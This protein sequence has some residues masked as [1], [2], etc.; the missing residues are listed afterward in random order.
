M[1]LHANA[2][3][4]CRQ[5]PVRSRLSMLGRLLFVT[6]A[7]TLCAL[8]VR[9]AELAATPDRQRAKLPIS[10]GMPRVRLQRPRQ[11]T[12]DNGMRLLVL[13]RSQ[14]VPTFTARMVLTSAGGL[15]EPSTR[16]GLAEFTAEMLRE[17]T[18]TRAA[19]EVARQLEMLG[20]TLEVDASLSTSSASLTVAGLAI[21]VDPALELLADMI[22]NPTFRSDEAAHYASR[23]IA[24]LELQRA[25]PEF[26]SQE[27]LLGAIYGNHPAA[28][29]APE[30]ASI[31]ATTTDD[32][33]HFHTAHYR[34]DEALLVVVG[35]VTLDEVLPVV[36]RAFG[37][38]S[39]PERYRAAAP[40]P[41][42]PV[43]QDHAV[44]LV[45]RPG[46]VQTVIQIGTLGITRVD[47]D[48]FALLVM[49][50]IFGAQSSARLYQNLREKHGYT[51]GAYSGFTAT[52]I[53]GIWQIT[54]SVR[55]DVTEAAL[56]ELFAEI[57]RI[58]E[59][60]A[61]AAELARAKRAL[62]GSYIFSLEDPQ[63]LLDAVI[64]QALYGLSADYWDTYPQKVE[65]VSVADVQRVA[66]RIVDPQRLQIAAVGDAAKV[67]G[68]LAPYGLTDKEKSSATEAAAGAGA[69]RQ[70]SAAEHARLREAIVR[71]ADRLSTAKVSTAMLAEGAAART[72]DFYDGA[73]GIGYF[74]LKAYRVLGDEKY[75]RAADSTLRQMLSQARPDRQGLYFDPAIN[76]VFQGNAGPGYVL[77]YAHRVTAERSYL[78]AAEQIARRIIAV[79]DIRADSNPDIIAGAAGAGLFL[80]AMHEATGD[81]Q[82]LQGARD[83]GDF[84]VAHAEPLDAGATWKLADHGEDY[85]FVGYSHGPAGIG[86]YLDRLYRVTAER[87]Y[88]E[89]ADRA[90]AYIEGI[91]IR[92][93]SPRGDSVKW[94]HER[95]KRPT[96]YSSQWCHGAPGMNPF[97][98]QLYSRAADRRYLDW[99]VTN[100]RYLLA[101]G[102]DV[103]KNPGVC[104][105]IAGNAASLYLMYQATG[106]E[107]YLQTV[108]QAVE[109]LYAAIETQLLD[110]TAN[111]D[112]AG[113]MTGLAGVGDFLVLLHSE[114]K[115][116]MFGP[117]G[118]GDDLSDS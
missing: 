90:M 101:Q 82:Y 86:Y 100:T 110:P 89:A 84:L 42:P 43:A 57:A 85:Y 2:M 12:L 13:E 6:V 29:A 59:E 11:V 66:K 64:S 8:P 44:Q 27:R 61:G 114:G 80:L 62:I 25:R 3:S 93:S 24:E 67:R 34:P 78:D 30:V 88:G 46:S 71:I 35:A 19:V 103:R 75:R 118:Y 99:A 51:Y 73:A 109:M 47:A 15:Y 97:F 9:A 77:L 76:G 4:R 113:Y 17:G 116:R 117:L 95:L 63:K 36:R 16:R 70:F 102:V 48:Y 108:R 96:R 68:A 115:L 50:Q 105:G 21:H 87:R 94:Y 107:A 54:T 14:Q 65:A 20:A 98:L 106:D 39:K 1:T 91:A 53:P 22:R 81:Q 74:L 49:N 45:D 33:R 18:N 55:T 10:D 111:A 60:P 69:P 112:E 38:W 58:R 79:P 72:S 92:E 31:K 32:L 23:R 28:L 56:K 83:L 7:A 5:L 104:H 26:I 37:S 52:D 40:P 41:P